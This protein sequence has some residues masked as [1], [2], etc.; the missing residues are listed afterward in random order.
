[1]N[2]P[3]SV[4]MKSWKYNLGNLRNEGLLAL[5]D[6]LLQYFSLNA[7]KASLDTSQH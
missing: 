2:D 3:S 1:M 6:F 5:L 4:S 7:F